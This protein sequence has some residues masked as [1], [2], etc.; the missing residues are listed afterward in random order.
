MP[1]D[2][3]L[4]KKI[5]KATT[6][7]VKSFRNI[8]SPRLFMTLLVKNEEDMLEENLLFHKSMGVDA[9]IV[10]D[11]NSTDRT[12]EIIRK[13]VDKGWIV[14][15]INEKATNYEQKDWVDRMIWI[16][17]TEFAAD[18]VINAD[19]DEL[20][21]C[22]SHNIK[23]VL[24]NSRAN[25]IKCPIYNIY[26]EENNEFWMN[27]YKVSK[28][29]V[30]DSKYDVGKFSL[31]APQIG[32]VI[33][34]AKDYVLISEGNHNVEMKNK[35]YQ[36]N[37][38]IKIFHYNIRKKEQFINKMVG[39]GREIAKGSIHKGG[40]HWRYFYELSCQ[41]GFNEEMVYNKAIG[42]DYKEKFVEKGILVEDSD[43]KKFILAKGLNNKY[44][45]Y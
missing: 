5:L 3:Y 8:S 1:M 13:Y 22:D 23:T 35:S 32:K 19:A 40:N 4:L 29:I 27:K 21:Y 15:V 9:F 16:A 6:E 30:D 31:Y 20:W 33:H 17:K 18:W 26:P 2:L 34:R 42:Y 10:T 28:Y 11:N 45:N 41:P 7:C 12:P 39:G 43:A 44:D 36:E 14:K 25:V 37:V 24:A 38:G